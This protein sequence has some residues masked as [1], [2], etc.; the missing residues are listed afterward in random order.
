MSAAFPSAPPPPMPAVA[1]EEANR[2]LPQVTALS[3]FCRA[4]DAGSDERVLECAL[5]DLARVGRVPDS[6]SALRE[7]ALRWLAAD[8]EE[9]H[10]QALT[11]RYDAMMADQ[12]ARG[13]TRREDFLLGVARRYCDAAAYLMSLAYAF[14]ASA[15]HLADRECEGRIMLFL[16]DALCMWPVLRTGALTRSGVDLLRY[17]RGDAQWHLPARVFREVETGR[18]EQVVVAG[19]DG[20][21]L[22]DVGLYGTLV[23][24]LIAR[25]RASSQARVM[26]MVSRNPCILGWANAH[27]ASHILDGFEWDPVDLIR[28]GDTVESLFK[29]F[30]VPAEAP[31]GDLVELADPVSYVCALMFAHRTAR[32]A[33][34]AARAPT[35]AEV[36]AD[37]AVARA[38]D[39]G[40]F[41]H[42]EVPPWIGGPEFLRQWPH[43]PIPPM[44]RLSGYTL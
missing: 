43:G 41:L 20:H 21:L 18:V 25:A 37:V 34:R 33:E 14:V 1:S 22:L 5:E 35:F 10:L 6:P 42:R 28:I 9:V 2:L 3:A 19:L 31:T 26:F 29:P 7:C 24:G 44:D 16:R 17:T 15:C 40:W 32:H 8:A 11:A 30:R 38:R 12:L 27:A 36:A 39:D 13:V 4:M 23:S